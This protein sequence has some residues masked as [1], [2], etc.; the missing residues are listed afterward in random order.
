MHHQDTC[1]IKGISTVHYSIRCS[2]SL[3]PCSGHASATPFGAFGSQIHSCRCTIGRF[4]HG[5]WAPKW[6]AR[7]KHQASVLQ[8]TGSAV[9]A[10]S[11]LGRKLAGSDLSGR[12]PWEQPWGQLLWGRIWGRLFSA[13]ERRGALPPAPSMRR[14]CVV[15]SR[16]LRPGT[17]R[18]CAD[19]GVH[20]VSMGAAVIWYRDEGY[21]NARVCAA[22]RAPA[23]RQTRPATS[24]PPASAPNHSPHQKST[25]PKEYSVYNPSKI[26]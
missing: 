9:L 16:T 10:T 11:H 20:V 2:V 19:V 1:I 15:S 17:H 24:P 25:Q 18:S 14:P 12:Q 23:H 26:A 6:A 3:Y 13:R 7:V 4:L 8:C 5:S 21:A 22:P